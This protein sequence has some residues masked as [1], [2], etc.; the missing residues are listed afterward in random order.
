M[1]CRQLAGAM[2]GND[3]GH[4]K[5]CS[6]V[7]GMP[8]KCSSGRRASIWADLLAR[9]RPISTLR[10]P[11]IVDRNFLKEDMGHR[12]KLI[13]RHSGVDSVTPFTSVGPAFCSG[14]QREFAR[15]TNVSNCCN[16]LHSV[17][18]F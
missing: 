18:C 13:F 11:A 15:S 6:I 8:G 17:G 12:T 1:F 16:H 3:F 14:H 9:C 4:L 7:Y 2:L 10:C 5:S